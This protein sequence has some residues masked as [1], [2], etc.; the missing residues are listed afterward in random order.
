MKRF[1]ALILLLGLTMSMAGCEIGM[2]HTGGGDDG[3]VR[4]LYDYFT[5]AKAA[6]QVSEIGISCRNHLLVFAAE[7]ARQQNT[8]VDTAAFE[9]S[10]C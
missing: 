10:F 4:A 2:E 5:G 1:L 9:Q 8:V 7:E 3:I 6:H